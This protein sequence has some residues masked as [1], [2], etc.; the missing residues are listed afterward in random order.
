M[1]LR[2]LAT[3]SVVALVLAA[4]GGDDDDASN[5]TTDTGANAPTTTTA[6][7]TD[8]TGGADPAA[9][10]TPADAPSCQLLTPTQ[11]GEVVGA[12]FTDGSDLLGSCEY[13]A[14]DGTTNVS[15]ELIDDATYD[16]R[17]AGEGVEPVDGV[18]DE[19]FLDTTNGF[20]YV[21]SGDTLF[22]VNVTGGDVSLEQ[23]AELNQQLAALIIESL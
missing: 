3:A 18:G 1:R 21:T 9:G 7:E 16:E 15:I 17:A 4:C 2:H 22:R 23:A 20:L 10:A 13:L 11:I 8:T 5:G 12:T 6:P 19:A 14:D